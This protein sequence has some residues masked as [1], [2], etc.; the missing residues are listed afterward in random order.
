MVIRH[1]RQ[2]YS[3]FRDGDDPNE[4]I[5]EDDKKTNDP[6]EPTVEPIGNSSFWGRWSVAKAKRDGEDVYLDVNWTNSRLALYED[7]TFTANYWLGMV[8]DSEP[9][10]PYFTPLGGTYSIDA[11]KNILLKSKKPNLELTYKFIDADIRKYLKSRNTITGEE[12]WEE[13]IVSITYSVMKDGH[14][15]RITFCK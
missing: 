14:D 5:N 7:G 10:S 2:N 4:V 6:K 15:Y 1:N 9:Y 12:V 8:D 11:K 3:F 13:R